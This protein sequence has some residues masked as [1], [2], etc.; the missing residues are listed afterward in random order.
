MEIIG[1]NEGYRYLHTC[2]ECHSMVA[3]YPKDVLECPYD[4]ISS[5]LNRRIYTT[6][7]VCGEP[8]VMYLDDTP[9]FFKQTMAR[10]K[11]WK[12]NN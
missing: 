3:I 1:V 11:G 5:T 8:I 9:C 2:K 4:T 7:P 12:T 6:C 10:K